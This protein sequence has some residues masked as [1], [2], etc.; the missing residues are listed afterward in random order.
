MYATFS[1]ATMDIPAIL[2]RICDPHQSI[3]SVAEQ[4]RTPISALCAWLALPEIAAMLEQMADA[5]ARR[6][7]MLA[8]SQMS[9]VADAARAIVTGVARDE[10]VLATQPPEPKTLSLRRSARQAGL[11]AMRILIKLTT[12][13]IQSRARTRA[14]SGATPAI[15]TSRQ[16]ISPLPKSNHVTGAPPQSAGVSNLRAG[17]LSP[18]ST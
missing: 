1:P 4:E 17:S 9:L 16:P 10:A 6:V 11:A 7:R 2:D 13:G 3:A 14:V 12:F 8:A 5:C 18:H 15:A